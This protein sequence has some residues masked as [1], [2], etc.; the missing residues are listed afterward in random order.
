MG[1]FASTQ[2]EIAL[3]GGKTIYFSKSKQMLGKVKNFFRKG[4]NPM[5]RNVS[6]QNGVMTVS[7]VGTKRIW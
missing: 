5:Y 7:E 2:K 4:Q 1:D 6:K 3:I